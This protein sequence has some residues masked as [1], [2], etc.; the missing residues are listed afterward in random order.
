MI[1]STYTLSK[2]T[3]YTLIYSFP[4]FEPVRCF[5]SGSS[6]PA[7]RFLRRQVS[8]SGIPIYKNRPQFAVIHTM[9]DFSIVNEAEVDF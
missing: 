9:I 1:Y 5:M 3:V 2:L 6:W 7:Y 4:N 8:W